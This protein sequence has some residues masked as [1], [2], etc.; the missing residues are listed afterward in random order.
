[1][2]EG[3]F[4]HLSDRSNNTRGHCA[5]QTVRMIEAEHLR[6]RVRE[7]LFISSSGEW[8]QLVRTNYVHVYF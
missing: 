1:M 7:D 8:G 2:I 4:V 5:A 3:V 6:D